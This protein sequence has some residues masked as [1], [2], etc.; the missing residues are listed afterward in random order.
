MVS[1][2]CA[3]GA[4][5]LSEIVA[6]AIGELPGGGVGLGLSRCIWSNHFITVNPMTR[7]RMPITSGTHELR[8]SPPLGAA[9]RL[10]TLTGRTGSGS[11]ASCK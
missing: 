11:V 3:C 7:T 10:R 8:P 9:L 1:A 4:T 5:I 6:V 2:G